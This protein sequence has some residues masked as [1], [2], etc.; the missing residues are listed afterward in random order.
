MSPT[1]SGMC[2]VYGMPHFIG[3]HFLIISAVVPAVTSSSSLISSK[4]SETSITTSSPVAPTQSTPQVYTTP[5]L[6]PATTMPPTTSKYSM[7]CQ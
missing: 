5:F 3:P 2:D 4:N 6:T 1:T 7:T